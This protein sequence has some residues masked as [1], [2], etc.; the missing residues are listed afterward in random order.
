MI[1]VAKKIRLLVPP[2]TFSQ[3]PSSTCDIDSLHARLS[4]LASSITCL[5]YPPGF[6]HSCQ[7]SPALY[8]LSDTPSSDEHSLHQHAL[9]QIPSFDSSLDGSLGAD[10]G[11][12]DGPGWR[13]LKTSGQDLCS[14]RATTLSATSTYLRI[15]IVTHC[16]TSPNHTAPLLQVP[17]SNGQS[18]LGL[19]SHLDGY[20]SLFIM[21][22]RCP[23]R[24]VA[25]SY[26][27]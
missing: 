5:V 22:P 11:R 3:L 2:A 23:V 25:S 24:S 7:S 1:D 12:M 13:R 10:G 14:W 20:E 15:P 6:L 26:P 17:A 9:R 19:I 18:W 16:S 27:H 21:L 8:C 4:S